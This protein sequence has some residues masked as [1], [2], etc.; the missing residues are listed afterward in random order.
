M[1]RLPTEKGST[2]HAL[3]TPIRNNR[4]ISMSSTCPNVPEKGKLT[5]ISFPGRVALCDFVRVGVNL[6]VP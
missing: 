5:A 1:G 2:V 6:D 3:F 4:L